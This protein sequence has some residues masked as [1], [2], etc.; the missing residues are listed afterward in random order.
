MQGKGLDRAEELALALAA[1]DEAAGA[2]AALVSFSVDAAGAPQAGPVLKAQAK[3]T[4]ATRTLVFLTAEV[5]EAPGTP[6][7]VLSAVYR[8]PEPT[9]A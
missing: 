1:L 4:R 9:A 6:T 8:R 2:D 5:F 7:L 3:V